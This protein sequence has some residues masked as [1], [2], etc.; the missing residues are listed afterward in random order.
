MHP[1]I[2]TGPDYNVG[3]VVKVQRGHVFGRVL[4][5]SDHGCAL[6]IYPVTKCAP[7]RTHKLSRLMTLI[8]ISVSGFDI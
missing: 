8:Y 5:V 1:V 3:L 7:N 2:V 6:V 4:G